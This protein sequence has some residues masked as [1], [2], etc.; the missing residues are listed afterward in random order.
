MDQES[1]RSF[2]GSIGSPGR[3]LAQVFPKSSHKFIEAVMQTA[4][5]G[6]VFKYEITNPILFPQLSLKVTVTFIYI[7]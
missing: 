7:A 6:K 3:D 2:N 4:A 1:R 5:E